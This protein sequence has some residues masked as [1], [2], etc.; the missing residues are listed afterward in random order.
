MSTS[1][2][3]C[4]ECGEWVRVAIQPSVVK[5]NKEFGSMKVM[6]DDQNVAHTCKEPEKK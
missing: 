4:P 1:P 5:V 2:V 6:F 3:R